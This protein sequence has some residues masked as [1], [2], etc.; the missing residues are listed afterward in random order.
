VKQYSGNKDTDFVLITPKNFN[1]TVVL[2]NEPRTWSVCIHLFIMFHVIYTNYASEWDFFYIFA[3]G[4][5]I[6]QRKFCRENE[7]RI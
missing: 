3:S 6:R 7:I 1:E 2:F 5:A 4:I